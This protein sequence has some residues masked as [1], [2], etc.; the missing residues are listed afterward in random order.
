M[1]EEGAKKIAEVVDHF[2]VEFQEDQDVL[3]TLSCITQLDSQADK[4]NANRRN[5]TITCTVGNARCRVVHTGCSI[6]FTTTIHFLHCICR[7]DCFNWWS[8]FTVLPSTW[9][10]RGKNSLLQSG[11]YSK[12]LSF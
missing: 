6:A 1:C 4:V 2:S 5:N 11:S 10:E 8:L 12:R 9:T 7:K 3:D